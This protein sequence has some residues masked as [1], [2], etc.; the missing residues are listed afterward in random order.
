MITEE[1]SLLL[2]ILNK[3]T[4]YN[5]ICGTNDSYGPSLDSTKLTKK[6]QN[7]LSGLQAT[8]MTIEDTNMKSK[9]TSTPIKQTN[10]IKPI[11][12]QNLY[13]L[14]PRFKRNNLQN[15]NNSNDSDFSSPE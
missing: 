15:L 3:S 1:V 9:Q 12:T 11:T 14:P 10:K 8:T 2:D 4:D 5:A 13:T 7:Y 6:S